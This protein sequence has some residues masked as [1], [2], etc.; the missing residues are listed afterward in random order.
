MADAYDEIQYARAPER[1]PFGKLD[2]TI[3]FRFP[4]DMKLM[5]QQKAAEAGCD[6]ARFCR[7]HLYVL[8]LGADHVKSVH[9][10]HLERVIGNVGE[11]P[12]K[13]GS[14]S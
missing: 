2:D 11:M 8:M 14:A 5:L 12:D 13:A 3:E 9:E 4:S 1:D 6:L 7:L 10:K